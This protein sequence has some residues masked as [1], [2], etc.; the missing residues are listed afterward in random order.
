LKRTIIALA[1]FAAATPAL[2][3]DIVP[4]PADAATVAV[5]ATTPAATQAVAPRLR[6]LV[7]LAGGGSVGTVSRLADD[8]SPRLIYRGRFITI[9]IASLS[10]DG[11]RLVTNLTRTQ[12]YALD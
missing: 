1:A 4:A 8:G 12:L 10:R 6:E 9:P 11:E 3:E 7:F 5:A 2:A